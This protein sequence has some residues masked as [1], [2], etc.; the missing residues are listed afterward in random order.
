MLTTAVMFFSVPSSPIK[1]IKCEVTGTTTTTATTTTTTTNPSGKCEAASTNNN[2]NSLDSALSACLEGCRTTPDTSRSCTPL[3]PYPPG[4]TKCSSQT[5]LAGLSNCSS[6]NT[7]F[8]SFSAMLN[9]NQGGDNGGKLFLRFPSVESKEGAA[10]NKEKQ[11]EPE[12]TSCQ[13][14]SCNETIDV[15]TLMEHIRNK[16]VDT[17]KDSE[18]FRCLWEGCKVYNKPSCSLTWLERHILCHSG[19][20]PFRCIVEGCGQRFTS[21]GGLERHVNSHFNT[22]QPVHPRSSRSKDDTPSKLL[23]KKKLKKR[24]SW[25]SK[26]LYCTYHG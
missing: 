2:D 22:Y 16:H 4:L 24:R 19:D 25:L 3:P 10:E 21:H 18:V 11:N 9:N 15:A 14:Q 13:W 20:K 12:L 6:T 23:K 8:S 17:Q 26:Y 5:S 7:S 1:V